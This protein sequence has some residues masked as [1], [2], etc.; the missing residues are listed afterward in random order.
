MNDRI[1]LEYFNG[2][3]QSNKNIEAGL[4]HINEA[5]AQGSSTATRFIADKYYY[6]DN[7]IQKDQA[8]ALELHKTLA[9][10]WFSD[11]N[12]RIG[13]KYYEGSKELKKNSTIGLIYLNTAA[14][15]Q[16][17][18]NA[19]KYL[20]DLLYYSNSNHKDQ[21]EASKLYKTLERRYWVH[22]YDQGRKEYYESFT[23]SK[24]NSTVGLI[25]LNTAAFDQNDSDALKYLGNLFYYGN[26]D[27]HEDQAKALELYKTL[28]AQ[29]N[30][31]DN[32][33]IGKKYCE[34]HENTNK[35]T[36]IGLIYLNTAAFDQNDLDAIK[37]LGDLF[38][39]G[40]NDIHKTK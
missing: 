24:K 12:F 10:R 34:G 4:I 16:K 22:Y 39:Y 1:G 3:N 5:I 6:G 23:D 38:Y 7:D 18:S 11:D 20:G 15:Y 37:Y 35:N 27:I 33:R 26:D 19:I 30:A 2:S 25:Y 21:A 40:N 36:T 17:N 29:C 13:K 9:A 14:F 8:K 31:D 32:F 28:A